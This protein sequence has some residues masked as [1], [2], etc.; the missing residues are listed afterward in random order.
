MVYTIIAI[1]VWNWNYSP[2][3][4]MG[5]RD[6]LQGFTACGD[7]LPGETYTFDMGGGFC[8]VAAQCAMAHRTARA[9]CAFAGFAGMDTR[10]AQLGL[11]PALWRVAN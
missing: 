4:E 2:S 6:R 5:G 8:A 1:N 11:P 3:T 9:D 7:V 10:P